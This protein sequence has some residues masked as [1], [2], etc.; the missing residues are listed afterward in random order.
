LLSDDGLHVAGFAV[1]VL[2]VRSQSPQIGCPYGSGHEDTLVYVFAPEKFAGH[3][4]AF[5]S[6]DVLQ[7]AGAGAQV[8]RISNQPVSTG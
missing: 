2:D 5:V 1:H 7:V 8:L 4:S 3:A 6:E